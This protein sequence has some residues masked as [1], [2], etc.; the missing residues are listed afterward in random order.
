M[1]TVEGGETLASNRLDANP[2]A[3]NKQSMSAQLDT[4]A[5][6]RRPAA[7]K[8]DLPTDAVDLRALVRCIDR[9]RA[10]DPLL[11]VVVNSRCAA[12]DIDRDWKDGPVGEMLKRATLLTLKPQ[13]RSS[14]ACTVIDR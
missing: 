5:Q 10:E 13:G 7:I 14:V 8:T 2:S 12:S 3:V 9:L 4:L 1:F 11:A 6:G